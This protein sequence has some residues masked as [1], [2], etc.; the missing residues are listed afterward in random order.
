MSETLAVDA[1]TFGNHAELLG[2]RFLDFDPETST[3]T[4]AFTAREELCSSRGGVQGGLV[5]GFLDEAMGL[6]YFAATNGEAAPLNLEISISLL[7]LI[8][9][10]VEFIGKGRVVRAG[11]RVIFL[12][13]ELIAEDGS[14]YARGTSTALP[15]PVPWRQ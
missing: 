6:A 4:F 1:S 14:V 10:G 2:T 9:T 8:P 15:S 11:K 3:A 7:K 12:E 13:G 5:A